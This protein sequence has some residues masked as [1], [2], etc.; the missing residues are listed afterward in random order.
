MQ[1]KLQELTD[2][3]YNEGL[4][5]GK[6]E[7]ELLRANAK[8]EAEKII[9]DAKN[10]AANIIASAKKEAEQTKSRVENDL[11]MASNQTIAAV[12]QQVE[13][14]IISK[15]LS[16]PVKASMTD[17]EFLKSVI[18]TIAQAFNASNAES[19]DLNVILPVA[20]QNEL[21]GAFLQKETGAA[22]EKGIDVYF[23]KQIAG[24]FKIGP[25]NGGYLISFSE[26]DFERLIAEYLRPATKKLLFG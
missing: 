10:E 5:K 3:L 4:S 2:K 15:A 18:L 20:M 12:K 22:L 8:K 26:G 7:A 9:A 16:N 14:L 1:N 17:A 25:K 11:R 13:N 21:Q 23:S 19:S 6:Q 24:G